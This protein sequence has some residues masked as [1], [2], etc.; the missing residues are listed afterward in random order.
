MYR[1]FS[2]N[3][4]I[5][6]EPI[7]LSDEEMHHLK[8]VLRVRDGEKIELVDGKGSL[9]EAIF[10]DQI[11]ARKVH[12]E[13]K[14]DTKKVLIQAIPEKNHLDFILEKA[15]EIGIT[16]FHFFPAER[17]KIKEISDGTL[18]RMKKIT[19]SAMKQSKRLFLPSIHLHSNIAS[20]REL[21]FPLLLAD[22]NGEHF[23]KETY[24]TSKAI[25]VGPES[26][27]TSKEIEFFIQEC[28]AKSI[29]LSPNILRAETAAIIASYLICS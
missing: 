5:Q 7:T 10:D 14:P 6:N 3:H 28:K 22:P 24:E 15:T 21:S 1:F 4:L 16:E 2:Q 8:R 17:S 11:I 26:G 27:L 20:F 19:I 9:A 29:S 23:I 25:L 12:H 13:K 18:L